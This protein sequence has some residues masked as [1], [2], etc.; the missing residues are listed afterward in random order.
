MWF[1]KCFY[2]D[3]HSLQSTGWVRFFHYHT[4]TSIHADFSNLP[5]RFVLLLPK[6][7]QISLVSLEAFSLQFS[8]YSDITHIISARR[9]INHCHHIKTRKRTFTKH[10]KGRLPYLEVCM[11]CLYCLEISLKL[12]IMTSLLF[13]ICMNRSVT[14]HPE[15][16]PGNANIPWE[17]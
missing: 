13:S 12:S 8:P 4:T 16:I 1:A 3:G 11:L 6:D 10:K 5:W 9:F 2:W 7:C 14:T 17:Y 15:N